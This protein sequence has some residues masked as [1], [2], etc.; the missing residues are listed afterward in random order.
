M[1][2][3]GNKTQSIGHNFFKPLFLNLLCCCCHL[4]LSLCLKGLILC[5]SSYEILKSFV[6]PSILNPVADADKSCLFNEVCAKPH[7]YSIK[8]SRSL[9]SC[10]EGQED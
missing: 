3:H 1:H 6:C 10:Q 9:T 7:C 4:F 8:V 2:V 5:S